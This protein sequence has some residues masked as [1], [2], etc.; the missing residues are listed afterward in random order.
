M[1]TPWWARG[2]EAYEGSRQV[3]GRTWRGNAMVGTPPPCPSP[4]SLPHSMPLPTTLPSSFPK[5]W[6][7]PVGRFCLHARRPVLLSYI[8]VARRQ[9]EIIVTFPVLNEHNSNAINSLVMLSTVYRCLVRNRPVNANQVMTVSPVICG[10][11]LY[12]HW[13]HTWRMCR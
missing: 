3:V 1:Q 10:C 13:P 12:T 11:G 4:A 9:L 6:I 5:A 2:W 8:F 7:T